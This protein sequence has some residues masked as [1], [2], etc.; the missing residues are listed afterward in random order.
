[1]PDTMI[2]PLTM[3]KVALIDE[4]DYPKLAGYHWTYHCGYARASDY[5]T[6][7]HKRKAVHMSHLIL[8]CPP[9]LEV[10]HIN[11]NKLDNRKANLRLVTRSQNCANRGKFKNSKSKYKGVRWNKKMGLWEAAIRKEGII[12]T[13]GAFDDEIAAASAYN[14]YAR[15]MWG[16]Y[17]VLNDIEE[18]DFRRMRHLKSP[19]AQSRFRGITRRKNGKWVARLT[20]NGKRE[21]LGY[22]DFEE[23]AARAFNEA[24]VKYKGKEAPNVI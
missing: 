5:D 1:M 10:D 16:E 20:I 11:R 13:I 3:G 14:E 17:A 6:K 24:Y 18:V 15:E 4:E 9:G 2:V 23:D 22:Y 8:P 21:S 12:K 19:K 7:T